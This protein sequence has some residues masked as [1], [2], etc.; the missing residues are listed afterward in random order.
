MYSAALITEVF[1]ASAL[2]M[3]APKRSFYPKIAV[4]TLFEFASFD[5][6]EE[7]HIILVELCNTLIL[8]TTLSTMIHHTTRQAVMHWTNGAFQL[9][10]NCGT[11]VS[12][13]RSGLIFF[14]I[15]NK[16][17]LAIRCRTPTNVLGLF[18]SPAQSHSWK[19]MVQLF[20][21]YFSNI[22][23]TDFMSTISVRASRGN[24]TASDL[25]F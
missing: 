11:F 1:S 24:K 4:R 15:V 22:R 17:I 16:C 2:H 3:V 10:I 6:N 21:Q 5:I 7:L 23:V 9:I 20:S 14:L 12:T 25:S 8:F 18:Y 19:F 13:S